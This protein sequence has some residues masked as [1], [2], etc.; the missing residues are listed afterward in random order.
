MVDA[1][2]PADQGRVIGS[3]F[4]VFGLVGLAVLVL[5]IPAGLGLDAA[6]GRLNAGA[7]PF[8]L[9]LAAVVASTFFGLALDVFRAWKR[10]DLYV[11]LSGAKAFLFVVFNLVALFVFEWGV[12]G[13]VAATLASTALLTVAAGVMI[14]ARTPLSWDAGVAKRLVRLG[15]GIVPGGLLDGYLNSF[16][17]LIA[18]FAAGAEPAGYLA[19]AGRLAF[20]LR[21]GL[22][23]P[24][25]QIWCVERLEMENADGPKPGAG[26]TDLFVIF[27]AVAVITA[28]ALSL[29][30]PE[31]IAIVANPSHAPAAAFAPLAMA[32]LLLYVV[33][34]EFELA[35]IATERTF[36]ITRIALIV[37]VAATPGYIAAVYAFGAMGVAAAAAGAF[38]L[39]AVLTIL[40]GLRVSAIARAE[41]LRLILAVTGLAAL[42]LTVGG[43]FY[44]QAPAFSGLVGKSVLL[45][46]LTAGLG[47]LLAR[48]PERRAVA[49]LLVGRVRA[50]FGRA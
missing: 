2:T 11:L 10:S 42:V 30:A 9:A 24:F 43:L 39:R 26:S 20:L 35:L 12:A 8:Q 13:I 46:G 45:I 17:K 27:Y 40:A 15:A 22:I 36:E 32:V 29:F 47:G 23:S 31:L 48:N 5:A 4:V 44:A 14:M 50:R 28:C 37:A 21:V 49:N 34:Y 6:F 19:L 38:G 3:A 33:S 25:N 1:D 7:L 18:G 41:P 16:D